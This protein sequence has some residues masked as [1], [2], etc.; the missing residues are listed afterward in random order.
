MHPHIA[1]LLARVI[2]QL[3]SGGVKRIAQRHVHILIRL[4][5]HRDLAAQHGNVNAYIVELALMMM[6]LRDIHHHA[7]AHDAVIN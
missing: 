5:I 6:F 4:A 3:A 2:F 7:A 1:A